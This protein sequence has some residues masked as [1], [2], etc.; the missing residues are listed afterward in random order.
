MTAA[1]L[2]GGVVMALPS[3][4]EQ[5]PER[6]AQFLA[7]TPRIL[8]LAKALNA[9]ALEVH[10]LYEAGDETAGPFP[11]HDDGPLRSAWIKRS[12]AARDGN[13]YHEAWATMNAAD[14]ALT[15][16]VDGFD[17]VE[18]TTLPAILLKAM[19]IGLGEWWKESVSADLQ[20]YAEAQLCA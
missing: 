20:R 2:T 6:E 14:K 9:A 18:M 3:D 5:L 15:P 19:L 12:H 4:S 7:L 17:E 13:G 10:R 1:P 16:L 11:G 8:P